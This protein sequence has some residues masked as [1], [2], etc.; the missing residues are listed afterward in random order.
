MKKIL[1]LAI[2]LSLLIGV[3]YANDVMKS[4]SK[5]AIEQ[6]QTTRIERSRTAPEYIFTK[7]PTSLLTSYNDY[8]IGSYNSLPLRVIPE[9]AG[10]GYFMTYHGQPTTTGTRRVY[11]GYLSSTGNV[12]NNNTITLDN[13]REGFPS[14]SIDP[15]SGK[16]MYAWHTNADADAVL[17][18]K[19]VSD[20]FIEGIDGLWNEIDVVIDNGAGFIPTPTITTTDNEF[21]WPTVQIGPSNV[22]GKRRVYV[23]ARNAV[24]HTIDALPS[25]NTYIAYADFSGS[26]LENGVPMNWNYTS[27][28]V[29]DGWN[30]SL[31]SFRRPNHAL[32]CDDAG[33]IYYI[34][35]HSA[36]DTADVVINEDDFDVFK[37]SN[38]GQGEWTRSTFSGN[39]PTWN[40]PDSLGSVNGYFTDTDNGDIPYTN[41][42]LSWQIGNSSHLNATIDTGGKIHVP[43]LWSIT[44]DKGSYYYGMQFVKEFVYDTNSNTA[45]VKEIYP[46]KNDYFDDF[47]QAFTPWDTEAPFGVVDTFYVDTAG[48]PFPGMVGDWNFPYWNDAS[49]DNAMMFHC[50]NMKITEK[51]DQNMLALVWQNSQR[52]R[53]FNSSQIAEYAPYANTPEIYIAVSQDNGGHWSEPIVINNQETPQ[54]AGLKPMWVYPADKV[55]YVGMQGN[56][57]VG[58]LGIMF[59][60]DNTWGSNSHS[61]T[62][63]PNDGGRVMFT[64]IQITFPSV[65]NEDPTVTPVTRILNQNYPNPFNPETTISFD[66][67]K[68]ANANLSVYNVKGQLVKTLL[69]GRADFGRNNLVWNGTDNSGSSVSSGLYFY[70]LSTDGKVE[71]RKMMLMK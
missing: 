68:A 61:P 16:P 71:T 43:G 13:V 44:T 56:Q 26:D 53:W 65:A 37:L 35:Y 10:G 32:V 66:M 20:A 41:D 50:G 8:M 58:K 49:H 52:A 45:V 47:N 25:E 54:F 55:K 57:K 63:F 59:Y 5:K 62:E 28:P 69:N 14:M 40:P 38:Y 3:V 17:E 60:D 27:I 51:N 48:D 11:Y 4:I 22:E 12:L 34:G 64:E 36:S 30:H 67:P 70:R 24:S 23:S 9:S 1:M 42:Q 6:P 31:T 33:S 19:F 15:V 7:T 21:I 18:V 46:N 2:C 29:L 39:I